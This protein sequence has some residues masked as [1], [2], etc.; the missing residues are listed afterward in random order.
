M[1]RKVSARLDLSPE[2][3]RLFEEA[4]NKSQL[5][6]E[7][8][9]FYAHHGQTILKY[10]KSVKEELQT[11]RKMLDE[12]LQMVAHDG[13]NEVIEKIKEKIEKAE[14]STLPDD[15]I[16]NEDPEIQ[17]AISNTLK[18]FLGDDV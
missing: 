1:K 16:A 5:I 18:A 10:G 8:I 15:P 12:L 4:K 7:A 11:I 17:E 3:E 2:A 13:N 6:N 9:E 14:E